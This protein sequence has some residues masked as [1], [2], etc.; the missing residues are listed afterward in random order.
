M[1]VTDGGSVHEAV[2]SFADRE[3]FHE[4]VA[5]LRAAGFA[6]SDLSVLA[7]HRNLGATDVS[8][9]EL[10]RTGLGDEIK[11][12]APLTIAGMVLISGGP[13]AAAIAA[14]VGAGLGGAALKDSSTTTPHRRTGRNLPLRSMPVQ[15]SSGSGAP[16]QRRRNAPSTCSNEPA[17]RMSTFTQGGA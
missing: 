5:E 2:A 1:A 8:R 15:Y 6:P 11:Y 4:A 17:G 14:L 13:V 7:T 16:T 3:H 10:I 9:S 12:L